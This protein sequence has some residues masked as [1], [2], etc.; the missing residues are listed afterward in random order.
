M[1]Q[2]NYTCTVGIYT[3]HIGAP[4]RRIQKGVIVE[5]QK[6]L[7]FR[8]KNR[9]G[10]TVLSVVLCFVLSPLV[11]MAAMMPQVLSIMPVVLMVLLGFVG[12]VSAVVCAGVCVGVGGT[13]FGV[14]G[15]VGALLLFVPVSI[16]SA[17]LVEKRRPFW[18][19]AGLATA[20]MFISMGLVVGFLTVLTGSDVV[21]AFTELVREMFTSL[22]S[23][24]DSMLLM[25]AQLGVVSVDGLDLSAQ[26]MGVILTQ[27]MRTEMINSIALILDSGLRLELPAQMATGS[28]LTGVLGQV[29]LRR[30]VLRRGVEVPYPKLR[31]WHLPKGWG[32]VLG[33][34]LLVFYLAAQ[35]MPEQMYSTFYVFMQVVE[36][37]FAVQGVAAVCYM[38]HKRGKGK[39]WRVLVIIAGCFVVRSVALA[40]G[41]ADQGMDITRRRAELDSEDNPYD[42]F[43]RGR[44]VA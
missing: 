32:R 36:M 40:V 31:T 38:L 42:P 33:G 15:A 13:L 10:L 19:S 25:F 7:L 26:S 23:L 16:V 3:R 6:V 24:A 27:E 17:V 22:G 9:W 11:G 44:R 43:G 1:Y 34:T 14:Y 12:P 35:M 2:I 20:T 8:Q 41:I 18:E 21:S 29:L 39:F 30:S 5:N 37:V 28:V 4:K